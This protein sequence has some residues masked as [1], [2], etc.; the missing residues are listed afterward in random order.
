MQA[1]G[2]DRLRESAG[3]LI[4]HSALPKGWVAR[5]PKIGTHSEHPGTTVFWN[6][7]YLEVIV[8]E[9]HE[10]GGVRYVLAP[11][12]DA[13][14][15]RSF[16][17]YDEASETRRASDH[18]AVRGQK[19]GT[20]ATT[21]L[22]I[23]LGHLP[24]AVQRHLANEYG[25]T[26]SRMTLISTVTGPVL[27]GICVWYDVGTTLSRTR[28]PI[29]LWL[30]LV[31]IVMFLDSALRFF[32]AMSQTRAVGSIP[33]YVVYG[34]YWLV[35]PNRGRLPA[36]FASERGV[37]L[38]T[39]E[40]PDDVALRDKVHLKGPLL[41]LLTPAEQVRLK[42]RFGFDYRRNS[43]VLAWIIL[44][45]AAMGSVS[46]LVKTLDSGSINAGVAFI[47]ATVLAVEQ[48]K[49]LAALQRGP[50]GSILGSLV[51]PFVRDL[52]ENG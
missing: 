15:I 19:F 25:V 48:I 46:S 4:L 7:R 28:S 29:P 35:S 49:R 44:V 31:A 1:Y 12:S 42:D 2:G 16:E 38:F 22:S 32:I 41:S 36:P 40:A 21:L 52:L 39:I 3:K 6:E 30:W 13:H 11:W 51:R 43:Y 27:M 20:F 18:A 10:R 8:A 45:F 47:V 23:F 50:A 9:S 26:A 34:V 17:V 14:T 33:G 24:A 37:G 5:T